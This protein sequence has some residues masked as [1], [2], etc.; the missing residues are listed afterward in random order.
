MLALCSL[1]AENLGPAKLRDSIQIRIEVTGRFEISESAAP[2][3][4]PQTALTVQQKT[5]TFAPL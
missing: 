4:V 2:A 5:S 3:V 1:F